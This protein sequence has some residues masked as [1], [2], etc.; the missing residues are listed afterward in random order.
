MYKYIL[1]ILCFFFVTGCTTSGTA[2]LGPI[3]TG[4]KSGSIYQTSLSYGSSSVIKNLKITN[5]FYQLNTKGKFRSNNPILPDIPYVDK[6][7]E[8]IMAYKVK[9]V[10]ISNV[11]E[12]EP[13]P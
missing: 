9:L 2:L 11:L 4:A 1:T 6:N 13:L 5:P 12:P 7:P 10:Q 3:I 8:I